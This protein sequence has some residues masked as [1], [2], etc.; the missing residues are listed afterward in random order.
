MSDSSSR[1]RSSD[2]VQRFW[3]LWQSGRR[4]ELREFLDDAGPLTADQLLAVVRLDQQQRWQ[5]GDRIAAEDYFRLCPLLDAYSENAI[6]V[7]YGEFLLRKQLGERPE[8][9]EYLRRFP[10]YCRQLRLQFDLYRAL[11]DEA[12]SSGGDAPPDERPNVPGFELLE[13]LGR[14]STGTVY[15]ARRTENV[16]DIALKVLRADVRFGSQERARFQA[17]GEAISRLRHP[18]VVRILEV[19]EWVGRPYLALEF[20]AGGSLA[21][22]LASGPLSIDES[23]RLTETLARAVQHVHNHNILHRDLNPANVLLTPAGEPKITDFGLAK[24]VRTG[25]DLT[26]SGTV[27]GTPGYMA[28]EQA[29]GRT[30]DIGPTTD[31]HALGAILYHLLTGRPPYDEGGLIPTLLKVRS[32]EMPAPV[33]AT[34]PEVSESLDRLCLRCLSK[35]M[36]ERPATA[37]MLAEELAALRPRSPV[38]EERVAK[39]CLVECVTGQVVPLE[40]AELVLGRAPECEVRLRSPSVSRRHCRIRCVGHQVLVEDLGSTWGIR[41]NGQQVECRDLRNGDRL[42]VGEVVFFVRLS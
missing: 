28:P 10:R 29:A 22:R 23:I 1:K 8:P 25:P 34:C 33:R 32:S 41:V 13:E 40:G 39:R 3:H 27:L 42:E 31:V 7:V 30:R 19:G 9:D 24:I 17:E 16:E 15:R 14:G 6:L 5:A 2:P 35:Q 4:P 36:R 11:Q 20:V 18:H 37:L 21:R 12:S 38:P 26:R